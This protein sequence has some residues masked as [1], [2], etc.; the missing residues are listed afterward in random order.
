[1]STHCKKAKD[2][3]RNNSV[4]DKESKPRLKWQ[5]CHNKDK[6]RTLAAKSIDL[7]SDDLDGHFGARSLLQRKT[8]SGQMHQYRPVG[9]EAATD[10]WP[11][12]SSSITRR[13][14]LPFRGMTI[15]V[16]AD[17]NAAAGLPIDPEGDQEA[18][19]SPDIKEV[20][21][22]TEG[23]QEVFSFTFF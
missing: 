15:K 3:D 14:V 8:A 10:P 22:D 20:T 13:R 23:A 4:D 12:N 7:T 9:L 2:T 19:P 21:P 16:T 6:H 1:M 17:M 11:A 18:D 5:A